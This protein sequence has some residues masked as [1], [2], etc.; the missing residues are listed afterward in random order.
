[1]KMKQL[2]TL[3]ALISVSLSVTF[4]S[5]TLG[6]L[7]PLSQVNTV[8]KE[9]TLANHV[10][11][12]DASLAIRKIMGG[13]NKRVIKFVLQQPVGKPG[14]KAWREM[15]VYDPEGVK[16]MFIMTFKENGQGS[17]DFA[18]KPM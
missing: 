15:W 4:C 1:M 16:K 12:Q 2:F 18:I 7:P 13:R 3:V 11:A 17:A 14:N 6:D 10:L 9:G 5:S 8:A